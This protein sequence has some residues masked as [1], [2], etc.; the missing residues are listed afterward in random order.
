MRL[1]ARI[2]LCE[3]MELEIETREHL[4][5]VTGFE[6]LRNILNDVNDPGAKKMLAALPD[7]KGLR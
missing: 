6:E 1:K 3:S 2:P 5:A 4:N 7:T